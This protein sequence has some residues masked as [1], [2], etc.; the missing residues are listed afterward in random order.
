MQITDLTKPASFSELIRWLLFFAIALGLVNLLAFA[1]EREESPGQSS[2]DF[3]GPPFFLE[4][5]LVITP[6]VWNVIAKPIHPVMGTDGRIHLAYEMLF[7]NISTSTVHL[8]TIEVVDPT[9]NNRVVGTDRVVTIKNEDVTTKFRLL[10]LKAPMLDLADFSSRLRPGRS[11]IL[12]LDVTFDDLRDMPRRIKHRVTVSQTDA[13]NNPVLITGVGDL[14]NISETEAV[15]LTPPLRGDRWVDAS[16]CCAIISPHRYTI[17]PTNGTLRPPEKY[18]IDFIQL[19]AQGRALVGDLKDLHNWPFYGADVLAAAAGKVV[20]V[21]DDLPDQVPG[22]L[23][24][25]I[26]AA[27]AAGNHVIVDIGH[28]RF[29]LYAHLIPGSVGVSEGQFVAQGQFLG[30]LGNSGNTDAPHLHFQVMNRPSA[31]DANGLPFVF[32]R[33]ELRGRFAGTLD[34]LNTAAFSGGV[35]Q[36][37]PGGSGE[38]KK[39]MPLTLDVLDF[40]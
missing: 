2:E 34:Q 26:T 4:K 16:G 1:Q 30:R 37:D 36:I 25:N 33:M 27:D 23:P 13:Q 29:I 32:R 20:E 3:S 10:A 7:T 17:L 11:A 24:S 28:R 40:K 18:A 9:Q 19:D 14:T 5:P 31:L 15:V 8:K 38:R 39:E 35:L 12:F 6:V 22:Q 21:V